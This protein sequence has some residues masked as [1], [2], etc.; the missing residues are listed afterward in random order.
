[1]TLRIILLSLLTPVLAFCGDLLFIGSSNDEGLGGIYVSEFADGALTE[2]KQVA[3]LPRKVSIEL[4]RDQKTLY[5]SMTTAQSG[6]NGEL[7]AWRILEDGGLEEINRSSS[8]VDHFCSLAQSPNGRHL[9]GTSFGLGIVSSFALTFRNGISTLTSQVELPRFPKGKR[10]LARAHDV[11]FSNDGRFVFVADIANNR[12]YTFSLDQETG[13][14]EEVGFVTSDAFVGPRHLILNQEGN[15]VYVLCQRGSNVT[16]FRHNGEGQ[17]TEFQTVPTLPQGYDGKTNHSAEVLLHPSGRF[18][19]A[20]NRGADSLAVFQV[21]AEGT[22]TSQ[23][24]ISSGGESPWSFEF[25]SAGKHLICSNLK[26]NNL[27]VFEIN[28][29]TGKLLPISEVT[30]PAPISTALRKG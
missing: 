20:S 17:L 14:L 7:I 27:V 8:G 15:V 1:M 13:K 11:E 28:P 2:P 21:N 30:V 19:Y 9:V 29:Y 4:S 3:K 16:A 6:E 22:L 23:Q 18:L 26:S 10:T 5:A 24:I 12:V 25:D